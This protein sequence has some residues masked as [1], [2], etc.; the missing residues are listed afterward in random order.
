MMNDEMTLGERGNT[1]GNTGE[2]K[3]DRQSKLKILKNR[4]EATTTTGKTN[5]TVTI[6]MYRYDFDDD[7][8]YEERRKE[9]RWKRCDCFLRG[10]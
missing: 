9:E 2:V 10:T 1:K 8:S 6:Q 5:E 7:E 4:E 3:V